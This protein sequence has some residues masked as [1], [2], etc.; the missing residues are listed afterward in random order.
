MIRLT[1][2]A[3]AALAACSGSTSVRPFGGAYT[4]ITVNGLPEPQP[5][6]RNTN[7][8]EIAGGALTVG[9]DTL[10]FDLALQPVDANGR[11]VGDTVSFEARIPY[12]RQG[13]S[14]LLEGEGLGAG[15]IVG[16]SVRLVL[17]SPAN[18]TGFTS[19]ANRYLF[20]PR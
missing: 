7:N 4:L 2:V 9:P 16:S 6:Y 3:V 1:V 20:A 18:S 13:D 5:L 14:L 10:Y 12:A 8:P 17:E 19:G 11:A 15:T